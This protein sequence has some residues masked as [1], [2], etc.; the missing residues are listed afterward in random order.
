MTRTRMFYEGKNAD[1][2]YST[3]VFTVNGKGD[4]GNCEPW[5]EA[6]DL[7]AFDL[8]NFIPD[9]LIECGYDGELTTAFFE[10][11][12]VWFCNKD[13]WGVGEWKETVEAAY[14]E[15]KQQRL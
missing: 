5:D 9:Y 11:D 1:S 12:V 8:A 3:F 4:W 13:D 15:W 14:R 6:D 7:V 10:G 2:Q